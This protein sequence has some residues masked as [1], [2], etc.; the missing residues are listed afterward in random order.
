MPLT[1]SIGEGPLAA[2]R[3]DTQVKLHELLQSC[4]EGESLL[5]ISVEF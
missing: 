4:R 1:T 2:S 5:F 3:D